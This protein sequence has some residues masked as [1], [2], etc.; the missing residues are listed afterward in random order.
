MI[1]FFYTSRMSYDD[2][3]KIIDRI[4][5]DGRQRITG[6][7]NIN[8]APSE[9]LAAVLN[10]ESPSCPDGDAPIEEIVAKQSDIEDPFRST[11]QLG[12]MIPDLEN[13]SLK[14]LLFGVRSRLYRLEASALTNVDPT[15]PTS[16]GIGQTL[17]VLVS[18]QQGTPIRGQPPRIGPSGKPL[19]TWTL[20]PLDWQKEGGARLFRNVPKEEED[21]D[22]LPGNPDSQDEQDHD[23]APIR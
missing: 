21:E 8:T 23:A 17:S 15:N 13:A 5:V 12:N 18:R 19:P 16:G 2:F 1:Q 3:S 22:N 14:R 7:I 11:G 4:T 6:R 20:R 9:V 10:A